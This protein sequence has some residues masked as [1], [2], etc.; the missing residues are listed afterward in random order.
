MSWLMDD[1]IVFGGKMF[2]TVRGHGA[3]FTEDSFKDVELGLAQFTTS[4]LGGVMTSSLYDA[5]TPGLQKLWRRITIFIDLPT[6]NTSVKIEHSIN[7]GTSWTDDG[8]VDGTGIVNSR[9]D[10]Y[11]NNVK[12]TKFQWRLT[13]KT[14]DETKTPTLRGVV[15]AYL[16]QPEPNWMWT[17]TIPVADK[18]ELM[19]DTIEVKSTNALIAYLE[20]QFRSQSLLT[21][22]DIDGVTW[23]DNGPGVLIYEMSTTHYDVENPREADVRITLLEAVESY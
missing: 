21:Y 6:V 20:G 22:I 4:T 11:L 12:S 1:I 10:V 14:T 7:G 8:T 23:A 3:F 2:V 17:F 19:D 13:L 9:L 15:V 16:P 5:G 18:W